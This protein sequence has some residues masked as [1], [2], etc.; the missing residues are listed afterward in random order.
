MIRFSKAPLAIGLAALISG[1]AGQNDGG[2]A[3]DAAE[4][5]EATTASALRDE[6]RAKYIEGFTCNRMIQG[7]SGYIK[8]LAGGR[9]VA[10][11]QDGTVDFRWSVRN[12]KFCVRG[13]EFRDACGQLPKRDMPNEREWLLKELG[14][15][16]I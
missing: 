16:C 15:S 14:E 2:A 11:H 6:R 9:G 1:C 8:Y 10:G 12:D 5:T 7:Q 3:S 13:V 4:Q